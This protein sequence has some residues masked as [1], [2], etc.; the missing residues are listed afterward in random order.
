MAHAGQPGAGFSLT[1]AMS[2]PTLVTVKP[3][4]ATYTFSATGRTVVNRIRARFDFRDGKIVR[5]VD[6]FDL[7]R[8][9]VR[10]SASRLAAG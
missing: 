8:W 9:R 10:H 3:A 7:W 2:A 6:S 1:L 4:V 5:H